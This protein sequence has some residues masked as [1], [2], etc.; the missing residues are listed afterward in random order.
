MAGPFPA[1]G[2]DMLVTLSSFTGLGNGHVGKAEEL[3]TDPIP[4]PHGKQAEY[5]LVVHSFV[6]AH[7]FADLWRPRYGTPKWGPEPPYPAHDIHLEADLVV[8]RGGMA[9]AELHGLKGFAIYPHPPHVGNIDS[10][11]T[12]WE[13]QLRMGQ[14]AGRQIKQNQPYWRKVTDAIHAYAPVA[15]CAGCGI[16]LPKTNRKQCGG[17]CK[18]ARYCGQQCQASD[19]KLLH[20]NECKAL[21][22]FFAAQDCQFCKA[23]F[24]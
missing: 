1:V 10:A 14:R 17:G 6:N 22:E 9:F 2:D 4:N 12:Y 13:E 11:R 24:L 8:W 15:F 5:Y 18:I 20:K 21:K 3:P 7:L 23:R 16:R 19:W